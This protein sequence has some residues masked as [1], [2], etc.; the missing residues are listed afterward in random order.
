MSFFKDS[1]TSLVDDVVELMS[2][3]VFMMTVDIAGAY[4]YISVHPDQ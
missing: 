3:N 4:K 1:A 2:L